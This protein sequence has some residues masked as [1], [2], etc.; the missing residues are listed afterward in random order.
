M[1]IRREESSSIRRVGRSKANSAGKPPR[2]KAA[3]VKPRRSNME[4][5]D[6]NFIPP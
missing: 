4:K 5:R 1:A 2:D 6:L 3:T